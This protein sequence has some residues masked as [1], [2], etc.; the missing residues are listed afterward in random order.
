MKTN[1]ILKEIKQALKE[2]RVDE[3]VVEI[4]K[5]DKIVLVGAGRMGLA[6]KAF[7]MRLNHLGLNASFLGDSNVPRLYNT[8]LMIIASGSGETQTIYDIA[9]CLSRMC[10][11]T[12]RPKS[13]IGSLADVIV[14]LKLPK[15]TQPMKTLMEQATWIYFDIVVLELMKL[16]SETNET[17][18]ER[19]TNLE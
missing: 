4:L 18:T 10:L 2:V 3:L 17:M 11:I 13:R 14:E 5:A 16:L 8:D 7:A 1:I 12:N 19:H 15:S 6:C 9:K